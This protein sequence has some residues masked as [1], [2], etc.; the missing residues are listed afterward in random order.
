ML[1]L[2][3]DIYNNIQ[4]LDVEIGNNTSTAGAD[5]GP[6]RELGI[7]IFGFTQDG[8]KYF[9]YHHTADD[10]LYKVDPEELQQNVAIYSVV[11][12]LASKY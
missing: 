6:M 8:T 7:P 3:Q 12:F 4:S 10:T 5:L 2:K 9:H 1:E 11:A